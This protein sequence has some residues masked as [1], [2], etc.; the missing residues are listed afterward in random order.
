V[1]LASAAGKNQHILDKPMREV[2]LNTALKIMAHEV[3]LWSCNTT[4]FFRRTAIVETRRVEEGTGFA[5]QLAGY[6]PGGLAIYVY[7]VGGLADLDIT[8]MRLGEDGIT[9]E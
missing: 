4:Y 1:F 5:Q 6:V 9:R 7:D 8:A 2:A 3:R